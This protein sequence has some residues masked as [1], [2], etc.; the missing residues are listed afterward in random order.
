MKGKY[1]Y[2]NDVETD[3]SQYEEIKLSEIEVMNMKRDIKNKMTKKISWK[4]C[5]AVAACVACIAAIA[6]TTMAGGIFKILN[7]EDTGHNKFLQMKYEEDDYSVPVPD[8]LLGLIFDENGNEITEFSHDRGKIFDKDGNEIIINAKVEDGNTLYGIE[9]ADKKPQKP[10]EDK[11]QAVFDTLEQVK[12]AA[13]FD[14]LAPEIIPEGYEFFYGV[15]YKNE[16]GEVSRDYAA[17]YY[18][19]GEDTISVHERIINDE[20]AFEAGSPEE[21]KTADINGCKAVYDS[22]M[23]SWETD[24]VS[25]TI[26][27]REHGDMLVD[28][29]RSAK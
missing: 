10:A 20:T 28:M 16:K 19:N 8:E 5:L 15:G 4:K 23:I 12:E 27:S 29:A 17:F 2:L 25:V 9:K 26:I 24:G 3:F 22:S 18:T 11:N 14:V 21:L 7:T 13:G 1:E 6:Q